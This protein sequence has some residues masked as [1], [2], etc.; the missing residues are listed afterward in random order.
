MTTDFQHGDHLCI[1]PSVV[2]QVPSQTVTSA[3][4]YMPVSLVT[5][6]SLSP[7]WGSQRD[8]HTG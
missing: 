4:K 7:V 6:L 5:R 8:H 1:D 3:I 2:R